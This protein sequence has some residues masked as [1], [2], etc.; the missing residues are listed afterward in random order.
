M[1]C[2][3]SRQAALTA[4]SGEMP[5]TRMIN[6]GPQ[7][8]RPTT[9]KRAGEVASAVG[10]G[11]QTLHY[12]ERIGLLPKPQRSA[13]NYRLYAPEVVRRVQFIRKAQL[14]GFN[15]AKPSTINVAMTRLSMLLR[16]PS[17]GRCSQSQTVFARRYLVHDQARTA[18]AAIM[19]NQ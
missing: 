12:Y 18:I 5:A 7:R 9:L 1:P 10:I 2:P 15:P 3:C 6:S 11:V 14:L 19:K 16:R 8:M 17:I 13:A 4:A